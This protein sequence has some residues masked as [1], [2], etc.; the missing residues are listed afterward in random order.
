MGEH[1]MLSHD[2][3]HRLAAMCAALALPGEE[4]RPIPG[5][6]GTYLVSSLGR[7]FSRPRPTTPGGIRKLQP[8]RNGY[9]MVTLVQGGFQTKRRVHLWVALAFLG[10]TPDGQEV[11]HLDGNPT[12]PAVANLAFGTHAENMRD[13]VRHGRSTRKDVCKRGHPR[14]GDGADLGA[15]NSSG[16]SRRCLACLRATR[17]AA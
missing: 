1:L 6:E 10:P 12:N 5:Y 2:E 7:V 3:T 13:M 9:P 17:R 15:P 8:D 16:G 4:W 14:V 11:R